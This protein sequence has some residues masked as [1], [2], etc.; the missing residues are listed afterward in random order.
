MAEHGER[1]RTL[2]RQIQDGAVA[3]QTGANSLA[4]GEG[5][6]IRICLGKLN[7]EPVIWGRSE[8]WSPPRGR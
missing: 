5:K 1:G 6:G 8:Q 3:P 7:Q 4:R 2:P